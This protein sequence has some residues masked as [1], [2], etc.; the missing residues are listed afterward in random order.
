MQQVK[1]FKIYGHI[2]LCVSFLV[3]VAFDSLPF[4]QCFSFD[5]TAYSLLL[6]V[7]FHSFS[8]FCAR[9][10]STFN[11]SLLLNIDGLASGFGTYNGAYRS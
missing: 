5:L 6:S 11:I 3:V 2:S 8:V 7:S 10:I 4:V 9:P 1:R